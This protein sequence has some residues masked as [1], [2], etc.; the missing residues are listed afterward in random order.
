MN[1]YF[2]DNVNLII[3]I[4]KNGKHYSYAQKEPSTNN[5]AYVFKSIKYL[6]TLN[7][8]SSY[9]KAQELAEFWNECFEKNNT[10]MSYDELAQL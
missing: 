1:K 9:K 5:L 2:N 3:T 6:S 7:I 4:E 10:L 8:C